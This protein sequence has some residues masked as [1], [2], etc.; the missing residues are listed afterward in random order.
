MCKIKVAVIQP[1][2]R[3]L[4]ALRKYAQSVHNGNS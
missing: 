4:E 3:Q 1:N 2:E